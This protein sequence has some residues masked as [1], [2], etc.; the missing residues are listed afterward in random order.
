MVACDCFS[1][2]VL[3]RSRAPL[4]LHRVAPVPRRIRRPQVAL[5]ALLLAVGIGYGIDALHRHDTK[6]HAVVSAQLVALSALPVQAGQT[7]RLIQHGGPFPYPQDGVVFDNNE[8]R[9]PAHQRGYYH[10]YTVPTPGAT[11]RAT[12]R[13]ITGA[14]GQYY[15]T[16]DHYESFEQ[17]DVT[18]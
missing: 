7:V 6:P 12:R 14:A 15:Y 5:I 10:E 17:V 13:M 4:R 9:L 1:Q 11:D 16:D 2:V 18:K 3:V 8:H